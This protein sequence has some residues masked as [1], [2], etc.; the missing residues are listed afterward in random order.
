M[1]EKE[2][3]Q[4]WAKPSQACYVIQCLCKNRDVWEEA[5]SW[6]SLVNLHISDIRILHAVIPK[7]NTTLELIHWF[8]WPMVLLHCGY[9]WSCAYEHFCIPQLYFLSTYWTIKMN[10]K[11][12]FPPTFPLLPLNAKKKHTKKTGTQLFRSNC[13]TEKFSIIKTHFLVLLCAV[14]N[15]KTSHAVPVCPNQY[16]CCVA[17]GFII[18]S[19]PSLTQIP[20]AEALTC[21]SDKFFWEKP[22]FSEQWAPSILLLIWYINLFSYC[23]MIVAMLF[24]LD[25]NQSDHSLL[26]STVKFDWIQI[27]L[28]NLQQLE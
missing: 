15:H 14:L 18:V 28:Y 12:A 7:L 20:R 22:A 2:Y 25:C 8:I 17:F 3:H 5:L 19:G 6:K 21:N 23:F 1:R 4:H 11:P 27:V 9:I 16:R 13:H 10:V 26:H 24:T